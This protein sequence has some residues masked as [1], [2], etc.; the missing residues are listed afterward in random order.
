MARSER[1]K[2]ARGEREVAE[3][4]R[5][6][7]FD[8]DRA[9]NSGGLRFRGDLYGELPCHVEVKRQ[10]V[11]RLWEWL[12]QAELDADGR[13]PVVAFRRNAGRWYA[14]LPLDDLVNLLWRDQQ[15]STSPTSERPE[16]HGDELD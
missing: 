16:L 5:L 14:T 9:P 12:R 4:F 2:G 10:E 8:C 1:D 13:M 6:A 11:L 7:G 3:R 15:A